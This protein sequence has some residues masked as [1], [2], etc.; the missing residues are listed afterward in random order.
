M[1]HV[2]AMVSA[3]VGSVHGAPRAAAVSR[4]DMLKRARRELAPRDSPRQYRT[5]RS[6]IADCNTGHGV[7]T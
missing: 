3:G 7:G 2:L 1:Q 4:Q 5:R 6:A